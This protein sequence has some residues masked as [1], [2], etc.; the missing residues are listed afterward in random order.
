MTLGHW[1]H[2]RDKHGGISQTLAEPYSP[3]QNRAESA[4]RDTK[5]QVLR[6]MKSSK[7]NPRLWDFC[8]EYVT[9]LRNRTA[10]GSPSLKGRT[11]H[12]I[13]TGDTPDISEWMEF[14]F[15]Q[16]VWNY[17]PDENFP[18]QKRRL[19]RWIGVSHRIG[20]AM[21]YWI[22]PKSANPISRSTVQPVTDEQMKMPETL[23]ELQA[24][25]LRVGERLARGDIDLPDTVIVPERDIYSDSHEFKAAETEAVKL[26]VEDYDPDTYDQ[27]LLAEVVLPLLDSM[28]T[29]KVIKRKR[30]DEGNP[31][32][33]ANTNLVLDQCVYEAEFPDGTIKEYSAN[34]IAEALF[35]QVDDEGNQFLLI[36]S[37]IDHEKDETHA[38]KVEDL[39]IDKPSGNKTM[40]KPQRGGNS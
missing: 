27:F 23:E 12:E 36:D 18:E 28:Q 19:G 35:S 30:D 29:A 11:P 25:D 2:V 15:Y 34:M 40:K 14:S 8:L 32:G 3:W 13:V 20:Q 39:Y 6:L 31:I 1:K 26:E 9:E 24:Y 7:A 10:L 5:R 16:P 4:I 21:C 38:L 33:K 17:G 22:L 37:I